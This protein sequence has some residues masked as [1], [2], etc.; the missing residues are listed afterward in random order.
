M[1]RYAIALA[2]ASTTVAPAFAEDSKQTSC[3][4]QGRVVSA[5]Q[6]ARLE[7]VSQDKVEETILASNPTWP[8]QYNAVIPAMTGFVYEQKRRD[9]KK[10]DLGE[11]FRDQCLE[12]WDQI[13]A[14][15]KNVK[16]N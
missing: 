6:Q 13:Q 14:M 5:I 1:I 2:V 4:Y 3:A 11:Q 16:T 8:E 12:N 10:V 15:M 7:R 9:L